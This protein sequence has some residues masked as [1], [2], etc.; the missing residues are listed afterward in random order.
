MNPAVD[1]IFNCDEMALQKN[2]IVIG[3]KNSRVQFEAWPAIH[4]FIFPQLVFPLIL[5][6]NII[7]PARA[8][9]CIWDGINCWPVN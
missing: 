5:R 9:R 7:L 4:L 2:G 1:T 8:A 6:R 3:W